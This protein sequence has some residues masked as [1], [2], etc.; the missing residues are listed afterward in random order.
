MLY[1]N[2][3]VK[4][5]YASIYDS[6][7]I[8]FFFIK[9][10]EKE[11]DRLAVSAMEELIIRGEYDLVL[12][13][14]NWGIEKGYITPGTTMSS[15]I[16]RSLTESGRNADPF[17]LRLGRFIPKAKTS[18]FIKEL[19]ESAGEDMTFLS[20]SEQI[21]QF[22]SS[23]SESEEFKQFVNEMNHPQTATAE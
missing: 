11:N 10:I 7:T 18:N 21:K 8:N 22:V 15:M 6:Q 5:L 17:L 2:L 12:A 23:M 9:G 4:E 20:G 14:L 19:I 16:A 3:T 13:G 1:K